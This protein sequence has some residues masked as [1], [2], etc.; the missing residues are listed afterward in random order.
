MPVLI[1]PESRVRNDVDGFRAAAA[2]GGRDGGS[3]SRII[4]AFLIFHVPA[5]RLPGQLVGMDQV[6]DRRR[7]AVMEVNLNN[8]SS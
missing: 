1:P 7:R 3:N 5:G 4:R 2:G 6:S 8:G